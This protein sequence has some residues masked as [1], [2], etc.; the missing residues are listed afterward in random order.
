MGW[1]SDRPPCAARRAPGARR[2]LAA[3]ITQP[4]PRFKRDADP[5][6]GQEHAAL[7]VR[8]RH[9]PPA[10]HQPTRPRPSRPASSTRLMPPSEK[11]Q[12]AARVV[13]GTAH[14]RDHHPRARASSQ[15]RGPIA[16]VHPEPCTAAGVSR[17]DTP[18]RLARAGAPPCGDHRPPPGEPPSSRR[19]GSEACWRCLADSITRRPG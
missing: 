8:G 5:D 6:T 14:V 18:A 2:S 11:S 16:L 19:R 10:Q 7:P 17:N 4:A 12:A 13:N 15:P 9:H 3:N 1:E